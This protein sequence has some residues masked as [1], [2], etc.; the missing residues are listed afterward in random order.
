MKICLSGKIV[1]TYGER[2][3]AVA[4]D[5]ELVRI[6]PDGTFTGSREGVDV[7]FL[8]EDLV[9]R[10]ETARAMVEMLAAMS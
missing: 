7:F 3:A 1:D 6:E 10:R 8:T 5:A 4:P 2:I 9:Y